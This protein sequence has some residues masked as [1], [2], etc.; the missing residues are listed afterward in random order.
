MASMQQAEQKVQG[1][2]PSGTAVHMLCTRNSPYPNES[3]V[4]PFA[5]PNGF[6]EP[7]S[8]TLTKLATSKILVIGAGGLGCELLKNLALVGFKNIHVI[9]MD[10]IDVTNLNRQFLFREK[11]VGSMKSIAAANFIMQRD[12]SITVTPYTCKIQDKDDVFYRQFEL[13]VAGLDNIKARQWMN[14][15]LHELCP[16]LEEDE[17]GDM[18]MADNAT[19]IPM[20]DGG[21]EGLSGQV[22]V[23]IPRVTKC[24]NCTM[25]DVKPAETYQVCTIAN[26][27]RTPEHC[28]IF[29]K[30]AIEMRLSN[31][32]ATPILEQWK[33][34]MSKEVDDGHASGG[35]PVLVPIDNDSPIHM[36]FICE[37]AQDRARKYGID[38]PD[39]NKTMG[40]VKN[41]IPAIA[42]TNAI[43]AAGC[44][45]EALKLVSLSSQT[46]CDYHF[47][48]GADGATS[49]TFQWKKDLECMVANNVDCKISISSNTKLMVLRQMVA[50]KMEWD[51]KSITMN[52]NL[53]TRPDGVSAN[54]LWSKGYFA[55]RTQGNLELTLADLNY[56][57]Y[58]GNSIYLGAFGLSIAPN[59]EG[60]N[61]NCTVVVSLS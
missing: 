6:F 44:A 33:T 4:V 10:T 46:M 31:D 52:P 36:Q 25:R 55:E 28:I 59:L 27:P 7:G 1:T 32:D 42:S 9:D 26:E 11:D 51:E 39:Y 45:N 8:E 12:P 15:K 53:E 57:K 3:G 41:I 24:F 19:C 37:K 18:V 30:F 47:Y 17:D 29:V 48:L 22:H 35:A 43:I 16:P 56:D 60:I 40:V 54:L 58:D 20:I 13:I 14:A 61:Q 38:P 21:T 50:Q 23:I 5:L 34:L 2:T 49:S